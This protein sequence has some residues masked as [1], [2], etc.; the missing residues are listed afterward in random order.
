SF[1]RSGGSNC[2]SSSGDGNGNP[3][4]AG[5]CG[6]PAETSGL[7]AAGRNC[8]WPSAVKPGSVPRTVPAHSP[9]TMVAELCTQLLDPATL[10]P[11][12]EGSRLV[13]AQTGGSA[14]EAA[15]TRRM[16][17]AAP[18]P[19][20]KMTLLCISSDSRPSCTSTAVA[21][22]ERL[23][24]RVLLTMRSRP[25]LRPLRSPPA[26]IALRQLE[27]WTITLPTTSTSS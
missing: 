6:L 15:C 13:G 5:G 22:P 27:P 18:A 17:G 24:T 1:A 26:R 23:N 19:V 7:V 10:R 8:S 16:V 12:D 2:G 11:L 9:G 25:W 3:V 20:W 21:L 14:S 4:G